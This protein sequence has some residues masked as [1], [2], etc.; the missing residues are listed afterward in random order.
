MCQRWVELGAFYPFSRSH[1]G[2]G[3]LPQDP[4]AFDGQIIES[5]RAALNVRYT[6]LPYLYTLLADHVVNGGTVFRAL[7]FEFPQDPATHGIDRQFMWGSGLL[8]TP[9]LDEGMTSVTG[10]FPDAR[11]Y[12][13][14]DGAEVSTKKGS[15][16]LDAPLEF[17][18]VHVRG[19]VIIPT[20]NP[21]VNTELSRQNPLGLI[22]PLDE[23]SS[24]SG[25]LYYD[26]GD[27]LSMDNGY[28]I[29]ILFLNGFF[30]CSPKLIKRNRS[31]YRS[32]AN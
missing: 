2:K 17:I 32:S 27:N 3:W 29:I 14:Y 6:L 8:V 16:T 25:T 9:V 28:I 7:W 12:S 22:V 13:Y 26:A 24:A 5:S 31:Y 11:F 18:P 10:Y 20:Q 15:V 23:N 4:A 19:G 1:N 30:Y 21:A